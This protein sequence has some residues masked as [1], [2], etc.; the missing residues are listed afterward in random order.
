MKHLLL[1]LS[2]V[3]IGYLYNFSLSE[4]AKMLNGK[5]CLRADAASTLEV[6]KKA[7]NKQVKLSNTCIFHEY[8]SKV[9]IPRPFNQNVFYYFSNNGMNANESK[10]LTL[11]Q[12]LHLCIG[13]EKFMDNP[14]NLPSPTTINSLS[15]Y[16]GK[17]CTVCS[18]GDIVVVVE[19]LC[20]QKALIQSLMRGAVRLFNNTRQEQW[21]V[22]QRIHVMSLSLHMQLQ[23]ESMSEKTKKQEARQRYQR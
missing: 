2:L 23:V 8:G 21:I 17:E 6:D 4:G 10:M 12:W 3:S 7:F 11:P 19:E 20:T 9:H 14:N 22:A 18:S 15:I 5:W 13:L 16:S 1:F